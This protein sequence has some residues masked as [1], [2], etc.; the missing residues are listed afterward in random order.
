M[1]K[2]RQWDT[3]E[4]RRAASLGYLLKDSAQG[5]SPLEAPSRAGR[6]VPW[7]LEHSPWGWDVR[8]KQSSTL[9]KWLYFGV[10]SLQHCSRSLSQ[11]AIWDNNALVASGPELF[12]A[13]RGLL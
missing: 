5:W 11:Y 13:A 4:V 9:Y 8:E 12:L 10:F 1:T 6:V 7:A 3:A 2:S